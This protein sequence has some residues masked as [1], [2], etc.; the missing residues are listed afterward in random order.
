MDVLIV[1]TVNVIETR[2]ARD[3]R[4]DHH[5]VCI[6]LQEDAHCEV[7]EITIMGRWMRR[8]VDAA[9]GEEG[10]S[11]RDGVK[12]CSTRDVTVDAS[13]SILLRGQCQAIFSTISM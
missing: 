12:V 10:A 7:S 8:D 11:S 6:V 5:R 13:N 3:M 2:S 9:A 1:L 4:H